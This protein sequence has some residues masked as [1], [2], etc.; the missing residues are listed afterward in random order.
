MFFE[1]MK[2]AGAAIL[3]AAA[4]GGAGLLFQER[5]LF[6]RKRGRHG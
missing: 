2:E 1:W 4:I 5:V 6:R 3:A